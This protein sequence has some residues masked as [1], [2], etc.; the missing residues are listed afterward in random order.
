MVVF[1][2][3]TIFYVLIATDMGIPGFSHHEKSSS[4]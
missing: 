3:I 4:K 1:K 2:D